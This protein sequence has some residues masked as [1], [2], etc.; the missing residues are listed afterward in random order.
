MLLKETMPPSITDS[1][2]QMD[3]AIKAVLK[4]I[5]AESINA[6]ARDHGC[7]HYNSVWY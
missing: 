7:L 5:M 2:A 3:A 1:T 6:A 4:G